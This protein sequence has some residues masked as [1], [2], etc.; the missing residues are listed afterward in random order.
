[1]FLTHI[2]FFRVFFCVEL[3]II[4]IVRRAEKPFYSSGWAPV[5]VNEMY[6]YMTLLIY[7]SINRSQSIASYWSTAPLYNGLWARTMIC[8]KIRYK[9]I[10]L[11]ITECRL[12]DPIDSQIKA[13]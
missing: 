1:M 13:R 4:I 2:Y 3:I 10:F 11:K 7:M 9:H 8:S 6:R 5:T 12:E